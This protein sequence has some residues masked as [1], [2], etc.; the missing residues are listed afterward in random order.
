MAVDTSKPTL[1]KLFKPRR[2]TNVEVSDFLVK[3][4]IKRD[5]ELFAAAQKRKDEGQLDLAN[6][7]LSNSSKV[8]NELI[9]KTWKMQT[10]SANLDRE[11][12]ARMDILREQLSEDCCPGCNKLWL[13]CA[14][15]VLRNNKI[16][17]FVFAHALRDLLINGR[18]KFRN[19]LIIGPT[20]CGKTFM[21]KPLG[22][23]FRVFSKPANDKYAWVGADSAE[24]ILLQDYRWSRD[25]IPWS[26]LLLLLEGEIVKLPAPKNQFSS[27]VV[28]D[29]DT[30][31]F[32]TS[33]SRIVYVGKFNS[34]DERET[35]MMS[36]R[37][38]VFQFAHQIAETDQIRVHPCARCFAELVMEE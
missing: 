15:E 1:K 22:S 10:A 17:P 6:F 27:D 9:A 25:M 29:K 37:W 31:I 13:K 3:Q 19:L 32:A 11:Q 20:N 8:L 35:E 24:I 21:L 12:K 7:V 34:T 33:K 26:D 2:L 16:H 30:P 5:T 4:N 14:M 28:I 23:I 38:K 18:G 36:S